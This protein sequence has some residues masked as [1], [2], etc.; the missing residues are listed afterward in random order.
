MVQALGGINMAERRMFSKKI[1]QSARFLKMSLTTQALYFQ[2]GISADDDGIV[3]AFPIMRMV[4]A[5]EDDLR[6]LAARGFVKILNDDLVTYI[7]DWKSNNFIRQDRYHKSQYHKLL[8]K[9]TSENTISEGICQPSDNQVTTNVQPLDNQVTTI[10]QPSDNQRLTEVRLG[11]D[12][13]EDTMSQHSVSTQKT[14]KN[15]FEKDSSPYKLA[16][17]LAK[18]IQKNK[19]DAV[20]DERRKQSWAADIDKLIRID[21]ADVNEI[22]SVIEWCQKDSFWKANILSGKKLREK[23]LQLSI[24]MQNEKGERKPEPKH[25]RDEY[26]C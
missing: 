13:I 17:Y 11:K 15:T 20:F 18:Q 21:K 22:A 26:L 2:L 8:V 9:I 3:E 12:S 10:C 25:R 24:K 6:V 4:G 16:C 19:P 23:Y 1:V 7:L 5:A 14:S